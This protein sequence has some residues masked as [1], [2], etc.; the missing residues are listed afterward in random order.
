MRKVITSL[1]SHLAF[2]LSILNWYK[3]NFSTAVFRPSPT[4]PHF[5]GASLALTPK[6]STRSRIGTFLSL[7]NI[8]LWTV[9]A[10]NSWACRLSIFYEDSYSHFIDEQKNVAHITGHGGARIQTQVVW[11]HSPNS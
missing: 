4:H 2:R 3:H 6:H 9:V 11:L 5:Q 10:N 1:L 7:D 8:L